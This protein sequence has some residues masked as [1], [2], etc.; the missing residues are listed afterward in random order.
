MNSSATPKR[1]PAHPRNT[2]LLVDDDAA[3]REMV[4]RALASEGYLVVPAAS[5]A[6]ALGITASRQIDL[7][8]LDLT[9]PGLGGWDTL[10]ELTSRDPLLAVVI[11]TAKPDQAFASLGAGV[12]AL[13]EKPLDFPTLLKI[14]KALLAESA[15]QRSARVMGNS[16]AFHYWPST[17]NP[18]PD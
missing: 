9:M 8:L 14:V 12:G 6:E 18:R 5:G 7:V 16:G 2:I 11:I 1:P 17:G 4:G 10:A 15:E 3:V 13:L